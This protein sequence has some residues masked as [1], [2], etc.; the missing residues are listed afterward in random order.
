MLPCKVLTW[1]H[2]GAFQPMRLRASKHPLAEPPTDIDGREEPIKAKC[3]FFHALRMIAGSSLPSHTACTHGKIAFEMTVCSKSKRFIVTL[4]TIERQR[5]GP[6]ARAISRLEFLD[7]TSLRRA[8]S[9]ASVKSTK[10]AAD[11]RSW[12][13]AVSSK[14]EHC[15][16]TASEDLP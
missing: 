1:S 7:H 16:A 14:R 12:P 8:I 13:F 4:A 5:I 2:A 9:K 6:K 15:H 11:S 3:A 10:T